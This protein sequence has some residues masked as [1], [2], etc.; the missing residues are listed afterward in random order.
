MAGEG[1]NLGIC[2][3]DAVEFTLLQVAR[4]EALTTQQVRHAERRST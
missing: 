4:D 1:K 3:F 2:G